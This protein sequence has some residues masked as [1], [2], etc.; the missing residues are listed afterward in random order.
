MCE[1]IGNCSFYK[2]FSKKDSLMW[3][4]MIKSYCDDGS[5]CARYRTYKSQGF[6]E[7]PSVIMPSGTSASKAF[8]SLP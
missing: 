1:Y 2:E 5:N 3:K 4:A 7:I 6:K 8:L